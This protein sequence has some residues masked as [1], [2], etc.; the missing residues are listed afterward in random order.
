M[1]IE[2]GLLFNGKIIP[3]SDWIS[4]DSSAWY[5]PGDDDVYARTLPIELLIFHWTAGPRRIGVT[6]A[7]RTYRAMQA[8]KKDNGA[9]MSVSAQMVLADDGG[10]FQLADL[11]L[12]C[13][14]AHQQFNM[15]GV[16][17]EYACPGTSAQAI[18][19]GGDPAERTETRRVASGIVK[20]VLPSPEALATAVRFA[21]LMHTA[22]GVPRRAH[23]QRDRFTA[24]EMFTVKGAAEHF[25]AHKTTKVDAAGFFVDALAK[26]GW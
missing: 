12:C 16:S 1:T 10:L 2:R 4:R 7:Q 8:R 13:V 26:A 24:P 14:H 21:E 22:F 15:R 11:G 19:L 25:H 3:G 5:I 20:C 23:T 18:K 6:A 17:V 9:E